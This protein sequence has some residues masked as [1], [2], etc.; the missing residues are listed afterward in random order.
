MAEERD[1]VPFAALETDESRFNSRNTVSSETP[2]TVVLVRRQPLFLLLFVTILLAAV[3][4]ILAAIVATRWT[5]SGAAYRNN[6]P[7]TQQLSYNSN[8]CSSKVCLRDSVN[9]LRTLKED[10]DPCE[11]FAGF[12]CD[13]GNRAEYRQKQDIMLTKLRELVERAAVPTSEQSAVRKWKDYYTSCL[14]GLNEERENM[15]VKKSLQTLGGWRNL[16]VVGE[17]RISGLSIG[18][19]MGSGRLKFLVALCG[20]E[21]RGNE[22][23][24]FE[25]IPMYGAY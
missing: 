1:R 4:V 21:W 7:S 20:I 12:S 22:N 2:K 9:I 19:A 18:V 16:S 3:C 15:A 14:Y 24:T 17:Y 10:I 25:F 11:D 13:G 6:N 8:V 23:D 5:C